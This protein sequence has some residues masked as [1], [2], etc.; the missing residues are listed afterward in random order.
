[1]SDNE[2][3]HYLRQH[4][5]VVD[6][7]D[8]IMDVLNT[9]PQITWSNYNIETGVMSIHTQENVFYFKLKLKKL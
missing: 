2:I 5:Y 6:A 8:Y 3:E 4:D 7:Q 1:M 9:S